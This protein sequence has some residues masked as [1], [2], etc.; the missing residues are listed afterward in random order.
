MIVPSQPSFIPGRQAFD[1]I[2]VA[3][4]LIHSIRKCSRKVGF[5]AVKVDL[6]KAYDRARWSF[7]RETLESFNFPNGW[8]QLILNCVF[9]ARMCIFG[10][11]K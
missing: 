6:E 11:A 3:Q 8:V 5:M 4:E 2:I 7:L 10:M 1:N 9:G